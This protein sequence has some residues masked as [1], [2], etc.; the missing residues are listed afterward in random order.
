MDEQEPVDWHLLQ[1]NPRA[2][3]GLSPSFDRKEL[4]RAYNVWLKRFK[5]EQHPQE[6]QRIRAAY[7]LLDSQLRFRTE[8]DGPTETSELNLSN[9]LPMSP[10]SLLSN[11]DHQPD[12]QPSIDPIA[13]VRDLVTGEDWK[14]AFEKLA[15]KP[16][17]APF[18]YLALAVLSDFSTSPANDV[19]LGFIDWILAGLEAHRGDSSLLQLLRAYLSEAAMNEDEMRRVLERI[20]T[21]FPKDGFYFL[22]EP[23]W[24]R[25]LR[26]VEWSTFLQTLRSCET[27]VRD[28]RHYGKMAFKIRLLRA[29]LFKAPDDWC[30]DTLRE[31]E[32]NSQTLNSA[33]LPEFEIISGL[34]SLKQNAA[35]FV[36]KGPMSR[37]IFE[38][39]RSYCEAPEDVWQTTIVSNQAILAADPSSLLSEFDCTDAGATDLVLPWII[40]SSEVSEPLGLSDESNELPQAYWNA[41]MNLLREIDKTFPY[42]KITWNQRRQS[43][44][45]IGTA[46]L[47]FLAVMF[48]G[49]IITMWLSS[50][51]VLPT[52]GASA[53]WGAVVLLISFLLSIAAVVWAF[54]NPIRRIESFYS[55]RLSKILEDHYRDKGR[56]MVSRMLA[57]TH[58]SFHDL[59][60]LILSCV[61]HQES[62]LGVSKV[63]PQ[64]MRQDVGL[65]IYATAVRFQR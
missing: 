32:E 63:V 36:A 13:L 8:Q 2:F 53:Q 65:W 59:L 58:L 1:R 62:F 20:A 51:T 44:I 21:I 37:R 17:K 25:Y 7:E 48:P 41:T 46:A 28:H 29:A 4:K 11:E 24:L 3:F 54:R 16:Y 33:L 57:A 10:M 6:F 64:F 43:L 12:K 35:A 9:S 34:F 22:S 52:L 31:L 45:T 61:Q 39:M 49:T 23:L 50:G 56:A 42:S 5:P 47:S 15:Q 27:L 30:I 40:V 14:G 55:K 18:D 38:S 19:P 60:R 26:E